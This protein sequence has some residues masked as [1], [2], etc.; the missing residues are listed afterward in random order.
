MAILVGMVSIV[1]NVTVSFMTDGN[2]KTAGSGL[3]QLYWNR[4][5]PVEQSPF[6]PSRPADRRPRG[7]TWNAAADAVG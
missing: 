6:T 2:W 7:V 3:A 5:R 1:V 4:V